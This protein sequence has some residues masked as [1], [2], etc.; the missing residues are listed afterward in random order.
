[1]HFLYNKV[2]KE[3]PHDLGKIVKG[4]KEY[5]SPFY[6]TLARQIQV[7]FPLFLNTDKKKYSY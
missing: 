3:L 5:I 2:A 4:K 6:A 7:T 1:M